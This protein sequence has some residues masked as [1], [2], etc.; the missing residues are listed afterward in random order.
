MWLNL[1]GKGLRSG[2][3]LPSSTR[4]PKNYRETR[5]VRPPGDAAPAL[6]DCWCDFCC[7]EMSLMTNACFTQST[8]SSADVIITYTGRDK[9]AQRSSRAQGRAP[10]HAASRPRPYA[11][12]FPY[13]GSWTSG[14]VPR[15]RPSRSKRVRVPRRA[16]HSRLAGA[17]RVSTGRHERHDQLVEAVVAEAATA[18]LDV[19]EDDEG[20]VDRELE[21]LHHVGARDLEEVR[22]LGVRRCAPQT[23]ALLRW[24]RAWGVPAHVARGGARPRQ[25]PCGDGRRMRHHPTRERLPP[26]RGSASHF[27]KTFDLS[28]TK[29][30]EMSSVSSTLLFELTAHVSAIAW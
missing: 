14:P 23:D 2:R 11:P 10:M 9:S 26:N 6:G 28:S 22:D 24:R 15:L 3:G 8:T 1:R 19:L 18:H 30:L 5:S 13:A 29:L 7:P 17:A 21:A 20:E 25:A 27:L 16:W 4:T 12:S